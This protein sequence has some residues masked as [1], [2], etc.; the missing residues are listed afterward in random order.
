L[1]ERVWCAR[2][3]IKTRTVDMTIVKLRQK[4]ERNAADPRIVVTVTGAGYAWGK[5]E[6]TP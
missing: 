6:G 5:D 3:D 1:L 2:P 4:I